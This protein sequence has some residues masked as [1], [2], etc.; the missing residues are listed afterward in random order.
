[1]RR[2]LAVRALLAL[3]ALS[4]CEIVPDLSPLPPPADSLT[5][6]GGGN[7]KAPAGVIRGFCYS[8]FRFSASASLARAA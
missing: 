1:M 8:S 2:F 6:S 5:S 7:A 4:S 3:L